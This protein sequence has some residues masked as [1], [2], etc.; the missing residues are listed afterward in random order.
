M[1]TIA[2]SCPPFAV[3]RENKQTLTQCTFR[4]NRFL[5]IKNN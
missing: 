2:I 3:L 4:N 1:L 5:E